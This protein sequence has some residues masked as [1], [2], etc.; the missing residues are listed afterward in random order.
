MADGRVCGAARPTA[1]WA[2]T[3]GVLRLFIDQGFA[4]LTEF[5]LPNGRRAD[6]AGLDARGRIAI[7]EVKSCRAD[8]AADSK[9]MDYLAYCDAFYFAIGADFPRD[10]PP[11]DCGLIV[12][13]AYGGA[14]LR[15]DAERALAPARR[16]AVTLRFARC[17]ALRGGG[18]AGRLQSFGSDAKRGSEPG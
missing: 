6:I 4:P 14:I 17:A 16:K 13:D 1:T 7:A 11:P 12:A 5:P 10:L 15:G 8:Y 9:W 2:I 18:G 3:R